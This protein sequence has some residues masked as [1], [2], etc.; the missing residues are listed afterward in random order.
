MDSIGLQVIAYVKFP[1]IRDCDINIG[2]YVRSLVRNYWDAVVSGT[3]SKCSMTLLVD[4]CQHIVNMSC[5]IIQEAIKHVTSDWHRKAPRIFNH[6][7]PRQCFFGINENDVLAN[8]N[9][10]LP[11]IFADA[12]NY[13]THIC[14][15]SLDEFIRL[16]SS[17]V[18]GKVNSRIAVLMESHSLP[19]TANLECN[20]IPFTTLNTMIG[21][22]TQTL[23]CMHQSNYQCTVS[24]N[25]E[26]ATISTAFHH[27]D[28]AEKPL[29][30]VIEH[31]PC[32][33]TYSTFNKEAVE[34]LTEITEFWHPT[35][36]DENAW[37][38][39]DD[40]EGW[41]SNESSNDIGSNWSADDRSPNE[42]GLPDINSER[43]Q[44]FEHTDTQNQCENLISQASVENTDIEP[45]LKAASRPVDSTV[46]SSDTCSS[47]SDHDTKHRLV[48]LLLTGLLLH[49]TEKARTSLLKADFN[50]VILELRD[51]ALREIKLAD[52]VINL[53]HQTV[54][55]IYKALFADLR[56]ELSSAEGLLKAMGS[57][58]PMAED[59]VIQTLKTHLTVPAPTPKKNAVFRFFSYLGKATVKL[60]NGC[61]SGSSN[62]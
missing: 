38:W 6:V 8:M 55:K 29:H 10:T 36:T 24:K 43:L 14:C 53:K 54:K 11:W 46:V 30:M 23:R 21:L 42:E 9:N 47:E 15:Q 57:Q 40:L 13:S 50:K 56:R 26:R 59:L 31:G 18:T 41:V 27:I 44:S 32:D 51:K 1:P 58:D 3:H 22:V 39:C 20:C 49:T 35:V 34:I 48:V 60:F 25:S 16:A 12:F 52:I 61:F 62:S 4:L 5:T 33:I 45:A 17:E 19:L 2:P 7:N 28:A 37:F